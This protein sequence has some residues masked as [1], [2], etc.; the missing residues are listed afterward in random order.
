METGDYTGAIQLLE[1]ARAQTRP[2]ASQALSVVS[3]VSFI[4]AILQHIEHLAIFGR[5]LDGT[6]TILISRLDDVFVT[7]CMPPVASRKQ[8]GLY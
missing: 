4:V 1:R 8:L 5:Y 2:D 7:P 6:L 3:L